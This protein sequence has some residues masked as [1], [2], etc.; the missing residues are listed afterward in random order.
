M[1]NNFVI[2]HKIFSSSFFILTFAFS[3]H[4]RIYEYNVFV[5]LSSNFIQKFLTS[6]FAPR[7]FFQCGTFFCSL[8]NKLEMQILSPNLANFN[9]LC[10]Y[11]LLALLLLLPEATKYVYIHPY[12]HNL[13]SYQQYVC[14]CMHL[15]FEINPQNIYC[16][17]VFRAEVK[18]FNV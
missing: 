16:F 9:K 3:Y 11:F 2:F 13:N 7:F 12:I 10:F 14:M 5:S 4:H 18:L 8:K 6:F 15:N 1:K 17:L